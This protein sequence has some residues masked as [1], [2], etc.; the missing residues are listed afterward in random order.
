MPSVVDAMTPFPYTIESSEPLK[1]AITIMYG[2]SIRH[3]PVV[4]GGVLVGLLSDRDVKLAVAV[5]R[6]KNEKEELKVDDVCVRDPYVVPH[7]E[8]LNLVLDHM[9]AEHIGSALV[10]RAGKL[11]GIFTVTDACKKLSELLRLYH[12]DA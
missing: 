3:L 2:K 11:V 1:A 5:S 7:T 6:G 10:T 12:P 8:K 4:E 9:V